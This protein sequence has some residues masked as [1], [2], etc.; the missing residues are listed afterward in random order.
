[1]QASKHPSHRI[2]GNVLLEPFIYF[3]G[4]SNSQLNRNTTAEGRSQ[5]MRGKKNPPTFSLATK[6]I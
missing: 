2:A 6:L 4:T 5:L 3:P 1:M